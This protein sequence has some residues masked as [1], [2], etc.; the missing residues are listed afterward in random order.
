MAARFISLTDFNDRPYRI[1]NQNEST[2]L[3][4]Y[5]QT[6]ESEIMERL[7]GWELWE[8]FQAG[9]DSYSGD[10]PL[11][12]WLDLEDGAEYTYGGVVYKY[13][14]LNDLLVPAVYSYW[15]RDSFDKHTNIGIGLNIKDEFTLISPATRI[16]T[17]YNTYAKKVGNDCHYENT[18]W[19]FLAANYEA[20]YTQ[21]DP[22][23]DFD[24]PGTMTI[25]NI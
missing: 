14:G 6:K 20:N 5:L 13:K 18:L 15:L 10:Y 24:A 8:D 19:G 16:S 1:P 4:A 9:L 12:K 25:F 3:A 22:E 21:W 2:D 17:A 7:L 23:T 11:D